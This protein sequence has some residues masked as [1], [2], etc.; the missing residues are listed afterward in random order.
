M[1]KSML[2][3]VVL[4]I[5]A[6]LPAAAQ[7]CTTSRV[8][9]SPGTFLTLTSG[10]TFQVNPG[11]SRTAVR[12]WLPLDNVK[13]CRGAGSSFNITNVSRN[14]PVTITALRRNTSVSRTQ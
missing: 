6:A 12:M 13:V 2:L 11:R 14:P 7:Q 1:K 9:G 8:R 5:A 10:Q 4:I 3:A